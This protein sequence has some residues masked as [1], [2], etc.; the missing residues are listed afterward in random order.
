MFASHHGA[1]APA[2]GIATCTPHKASLCP[3][4]VLFCVCVIGALSKRA[5]LFTNLEVHNTALI[6]MA[7]VLPRSLGAAMLQD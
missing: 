4:V 7:A 2:K 6:R 5:T 3:F 1:I